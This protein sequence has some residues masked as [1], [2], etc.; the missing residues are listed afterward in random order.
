MEAKSKSRISNTNRRATDDQRL[1]SIITTAAYI[2]MHDAEAALDTAWD[3]LARI[4]KNI[5]ECILKLATWSSTQGYSKYNSIRT[6]VA[7]LLQNNDTFV[8]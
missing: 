7:L 3:N 6:Q 5:K 4:E 1:K 8:L 2:Q